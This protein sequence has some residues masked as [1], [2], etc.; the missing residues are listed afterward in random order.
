MADAPRVLLI[1]PD[2]AV[3]S[4]ITASLS[5]D[6]FDAE[7]SPSLAAALA[8]ITSRPC[9]IVLL[10]LDLPDSEGV[11]TLDR[12][13]RVEP[14]M[15]VIVVTNPDTES[16]GRRLVGS[17]AQDCVD[18]ESIRGADLTRALEFAIERQKVLSRL[19]RTRQRERL[20]REVQLQ[21]KDQILSRVSHEL[22]TP[23]SAI[24][25]FLSLLADGFGGDLTAEQRSFVDVA[26]TSANQL[27]RMVGDLLDTS[28]IALGR[29]EIHARP[30]AM[31]GVVEDSVRLVRASARAR[32]HKL[33]VRWLT[34]DDTVYADPHRTTQVLVNLLENAVKYAPPGGRIRVTVR[35][36]PETEP[37]FVRVDVEDSGPGISENER[38]TVF[39][40]LHQLAA[41]SSEDGG[42]LGLGLHIA[43][44]VVTRH[45]GGIA[46][47]DSELGGARF[48]FTLPVD[49]P[50][51][52]PEGDDRDGE[53]RT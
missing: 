30:I 15:P 43:K 13:R 23:L 39:E 41:R 25:E 38:R 1:E 51:E 12:F 40:S 17:G 4:R 49:D 27:D 44:Q 29:L 21:I 52:R 22:R 35:A 47:D 24:H 19:E 53:A 50:H 42:G 31:R 5:E 10:S 3:A 45:G 7:T 37:G 34:E 28:R 36:H 26:L 46:V 20:S 8:H 11:D 16:L 32:D 18:R 14:D 9:D 2:P 6:R 33:E 48:S